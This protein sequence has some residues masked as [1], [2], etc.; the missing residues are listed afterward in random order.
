MKFRI[1]TNGEHFRIQKKMLLWWVY[2]F[3]FIPAYQ[4]PWS[5]KSDEQAERYVREKYG[6]EAII[7]RPWTASP[8]DKL[9]T[10]NA[11]RQTQS[12][13]HKIYEE[14][15]GKCVSDD[16]AE[17]AAAGVYELICKEFGYDK[18]KE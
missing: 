15:R 11:S 5:F 7:V 8:G 3:E 12:L 2:M 16:S 10:A 6:Q 13:R 9:T 17:S 14:M 18:Y 4:E 1:M